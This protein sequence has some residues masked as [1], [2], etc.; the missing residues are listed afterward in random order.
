MDIVISG[1]TGLVGTALSAAL[2][3]A[4]HRPIALVRHPPTRDEIGWDPSSGSIDAASLE[5]VDGVVHL[6]GAG[7]NDHR[8][9]DEYKRELH[10]SRTG[11]TG[12]LASTIAGL[13][14]PPP[15]LVS[16]S[17]I[18]YY[19]DRRDEELTEESPPGDD[20]FARLCVDW[21]AATAPAEAAG[22]R[23]VHIRSGVV[24][25]PKGGALKK[26]IPLFKFGLGGHFGSGKQ[27]QSWISIDD[28]VDA[29]I[30]LLTA[31]VRGP[32]NLTSPRPVTNREFTQTLA[33][34]L[35]RPAFFPIPMFAPKIVLGAELVESLLL[36][37]QRV[38]PR[39][40]LASGF[41]FAFP[42]LEGALQH[43]LER[44]AA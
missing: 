21:E 25:S 1:A 5:G 18:G 33:R 39:Q 41:V 42:E 26:Q 3:Q 16:G 13:S 36:V 40:L 10:D 44:R 38:L 31:D 4:G 32:V 35:R 43:L 24:L 30:H 7:I 37:S 2:R 34:T 28:E 8:W 11:P 27:W 23:V 14:K 9:N 22:V 12:L 29:I 19:G 17:A 6:A 15:V 20:F